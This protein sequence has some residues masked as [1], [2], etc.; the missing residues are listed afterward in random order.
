MIRFCQKLPIQTMDLKLP[1]PNE[2]RKGKMAGETREANSFIAVQNS[3][4]H[5]SFMDHKQ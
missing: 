1:W 3:E 5:Y 4:E 2:Y